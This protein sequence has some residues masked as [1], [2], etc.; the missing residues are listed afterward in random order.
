MDDVTHYLWEHKKLNKEL[1][2]LRIKL[3]L[4]VI[5]YLSVMLLALPAVEAQTIEHVKYNTLNLNIGESGDYNSWY[6]D[7]TVNIECQKETMQ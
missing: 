5:A 7:R 1:L 4:I 3:F 2:K 6:K